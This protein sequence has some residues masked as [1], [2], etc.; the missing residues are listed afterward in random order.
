MKKVDWKSVLIVVLLVFSVITRSLLLGKRYPTIH[1]EDIQPRPLTS[2]SLTSAGARD[3]TTMLQR[4]RLQ[5]EM[6]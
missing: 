3:T 6:P 4:T 5:L 2:T 1:F